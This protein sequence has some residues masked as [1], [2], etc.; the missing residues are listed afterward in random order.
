[1][2]NSQKQNPDNQNPNPQVN[3]FHQHMHQNSNLDVIVRLALVE[4]RSR[5]LEEN[6]KSFQAEFEKDF[7]SID[8]KLDSIIEIKNKFDGSWKAVA[9][10]GSIV[11]VGATVLAW[12]IERWQA[13]RDAIF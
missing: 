12:L 4:E 6:F 13:I 9:F 1:M 5:K 11:V 2:P 3:E 7:K 8:E 10:I